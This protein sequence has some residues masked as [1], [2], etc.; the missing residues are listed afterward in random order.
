MTPL[1]KLTKTAYRNLHHWLDR[2]FVKSTTCEGEKC[3]GI[4]K[5][6]AWALKKGAEYD[7]NRD[8]YLVLCNSCHT[9]YDFSEETRK[10]MAASARRT[11]NGY[12]KGHKPYLLKHS[13]ETKDKLRAIAL[14]DGR[15]PP[16]RSK[17]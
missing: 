17:K 3:T 1:N 16:G 6:L 7:K 12:K 11:L 10:K 2:N 5:R 8:S 4:S 14:A 15:K 9:R 13:Q